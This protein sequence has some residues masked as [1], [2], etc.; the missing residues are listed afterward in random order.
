MTAIQ[1]S[2]KIELVSPFP[3]ELYV[4]L[5]DWS[6]QF[7]DRTMDDFWYKDMDVLCR[8][9]DRRGG[10]EDTYAVIENGKP[11]GFIGF[12]KLTPHLGTLRGVCFTREVHGNGTAVRALRSVLQQQFDEGVHKIMAF[13]FWDNLRARAFYKK[14][15]AVQEKRLEEHTMRNGVLT[16]MSML[17][18]FAHADGYRVSEEKT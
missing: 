10:E 11:V 4:A 5:Y 15:G 3:V 7:P 8:E 14:L 13:P 12:M 2:T 16:D 18:F 6:M 17:S 9:L 1:P